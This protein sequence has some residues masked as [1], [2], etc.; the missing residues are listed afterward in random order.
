MPAGGVEERGHCQCRAV[1]A[2]GDPWDPLGTPWPGAGTA[3]A[4][5]GC[6]G[7]TPSPLHTQT[8]AQLRRSFQRLDL[9]GNSARSSPPPPATPLTPRLQGP[10]QIHLYIA[11]AASPFH[12]E[13]PPD[14]SP[15]SSPAAPLGLPQPCGVSVPRPPPIPALPIQ[16]GALPCSARSP[17]RQLGGPQNVLLAVQEEQ[18]KG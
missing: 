3:G 6:G 5:G 11:A 1:A 13:K 12:G 15:R 2:L 17:P 14:P 8:P 9:L 10:P 16:A 18:S 4:G 7:V